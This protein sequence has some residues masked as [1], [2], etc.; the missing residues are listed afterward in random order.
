MIELI[1]SHAHLDDEKFNEDRKEIIEKII[2]QF[3]KIVNNLCIFFTL[4]SFCQHFLL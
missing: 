3:P 1:D 4:L 2:K